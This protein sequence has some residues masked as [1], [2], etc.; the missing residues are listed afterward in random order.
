MTK[1]KWPS[2][3]R[4]F[5]DADFINKLPPDEKK[6][7][8]KFIDEYYCGNGTKKDTMHVKILGESIKKE[9]NKNNNIRTSDLY[10][11]VKQGGKM[12]ALNEDLDMELDSDKVLESDNPEEVIEKLVSD[13]HD[14]ICDNVLSMEDILK[15]LCFDVMRFTLR[16][17]KYQ[18][19]F[20]EI[21][22]N[23]K[24]LKKKQSKQLEL[25][26]DK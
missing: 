10:N 23:D 19:R 25:K 13:A 21:C 16:Q 14:E 6:W 2:K 7:Y 18:R 22:D 15:T 24:R 8:L 11:Y 1:I 17:I 20:K 4:D 9:L 3:V 5:V 12:D 26:L